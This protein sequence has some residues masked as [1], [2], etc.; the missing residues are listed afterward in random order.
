[1][2]KIVLFYKYTNIEN[3]EKEMFEQRDLCLKLGLKGRGIVAREGINA[4]YEGTDENIEKYIAH[5]KKDPR[6]SD[7]HWKISEGTGL[8]FPKLSVKVRSEIVSLHLGDKDINPNDVTGKYL[9]PEELH[10]WIWG[11]HE[12]SDEFHRSYSHPSPL[13]KREG[14]PKKEKQREFY[15]IDM[16]NDYETKSGYF[17]N[18][19]FPQLSNFRDINQAVPMLD[20]LRDKTIVTVCTGGVRCEK[21]SGFLVTQGFSDVYQL[22]CGI[23]SYMEKYPNQDFVGKLY[24]F[25]NRI[26]MGFNIDSSE[27][28]V[29]GKCEGCGKTTDQYVNCDNNFCHRHFIEC[30]ECIIKFEG[31]C[32]MGC[33][34]MHT[35]RS[36]IT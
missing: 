17:E 7:I 2:Y 9:T 34:V 13:S 14:M 18:S 19:I 4:T 25:D 24:V 5:M 1:M 35:R 10:E 11:R 36:R 29:V 28:K 16:R 22:K 8:A 30:A 27:H 31:K 26:T 20:N 21:A 15:I 23:V 32:P 12:C 33:R 3:P 6:F